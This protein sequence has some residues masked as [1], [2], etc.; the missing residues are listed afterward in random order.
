MTVPSQMVFFGMKS[1]SLACSCA[2][3]SCANEKVEGA[4]VGVCGE[5]ESEGGA[6]AGAGA[7]PDLTCG[8]MDQACAE[9]GDA[10]AMVVQLVLGQVVEVAVTAFRL[11]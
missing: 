4:A 1:S 9:V 6:G 5:A 10:L 11:N 3:A 2:P 7:R 8:P